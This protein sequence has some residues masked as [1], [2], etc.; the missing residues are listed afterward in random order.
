[1]FAG[2]SEAKL[3]QREMANGGMNLR[4]IGGQNVLL[5]PVRVV[6]RADRRSAHRAADH[7]HRK[8]ILPGG[9]SWRLRD[10]G[11]HHAQ[12]CPGSHVCSG[13]ISASGR[14]LSPNAPCCSLDKKARARLHTGHGQ[15]RKT[16][17]LRRYTRLTDVD[18]LRTLRASS[19]LE[20]DFLTPHSVF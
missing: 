11:P 17:P 12:R 16:A 9:T 13:H 14:Y 5:R 18:G 2:V 15:R 10:L 19:N 20:F 4:C 7:T 3:N 1:M 8:S 6:F